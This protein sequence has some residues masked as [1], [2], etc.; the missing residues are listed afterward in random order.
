MLL[1]EEAGFVRVIQFSGRYRTS[2]MRCCNLGV[3]KG[4]GCRHETRI[5][6]GD[7]LNEQDFEKLIFN[8]TIK[9][10]EILI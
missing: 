9:K 4:W 5:A 2:R 6:A 10:K 1:V 8:A 3:A 7:C